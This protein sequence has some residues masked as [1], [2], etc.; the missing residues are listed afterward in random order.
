[1]LLWAIAVRMPALKNAKIPNSRAVGG[2]GSDLDG[3]LP[4]ETQWK[5]HNYNHLMEQPTIFYAVVLIL[6]VI[7]HGTGFNATLAWV[8]VIARIAHSIW[9]AMVNTI[10]VRF[11][12]FTLSTIALG[13]LAG[14]AVR[15]TLNF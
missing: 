10:P 8:Y 5:A 13:I 6:A 2:R 9:Q 14:N 15:A 11:G 12:L 7:G 1:M 4:R 3:I